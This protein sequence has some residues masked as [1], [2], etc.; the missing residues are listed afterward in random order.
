MTI[1]KHTGSNKWTRIRWV[2]ETA[3]NPHRVSGWVSKLMIVMIKQS[4]TWFWYITMV[5]KKN[6]NTH[7]L[8][9]IRVLNF[10]KFSN[11]HLKTIRS[12][13]VLSWNLGVLWKLSEI[14]RTGGSL[15]LIFFKYQD[16]VMLWFWNFSNTRN[17]WFF[18]CQF[19][20]NTQE[21]RVLQNADTPPQAE[22]NVAWEL[23]DTWSRLAYVFHHRGKVCILLV[24]MAWT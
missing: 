10:W 19:F 3:R 20:S 6:Q 21:W 15:N 14:P 23:I 7:L 11:N 16:P 22:V 8:Y 17:Q 12:L 13:P 9:I 4:N 1:K 24:C 2:L 18:G 5:I